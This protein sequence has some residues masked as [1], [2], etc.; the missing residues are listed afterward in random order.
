MNRLLIDAVNAKQIIAFQYSNV[1][2]TAEPHALGMD[3]NNNL[4]LSAW[5]LSGKI[6]DAP[7]WRF[8]FVGKMFFLKPTGKTFSIARPGY[9]R[10]DQ[11]MKTIYAQ[12]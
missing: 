8:Y 12:T 5:Q 2:R 4:V 1:F 9:V 11:R 6:G 10:N 7:D 3:E